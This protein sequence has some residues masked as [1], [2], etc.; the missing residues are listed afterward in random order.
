MPTYRNDSEEARSATGSD[1]LECIV[2]PGQSVET[3]QILGAGWTKTSDAPYDRLTLVEEVVVAGASA[4][5]LL[6]CSSILCT[7]SASGLKACP[8]SPDNPGGLTLP[9][10]SVAEIANNGSIETLHIIGSGGSVFVQG[11]R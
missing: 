10:G 4:S 2:Q 6:A 9:V 11:L 1:G 3:Y 7:A 5:G 8:N